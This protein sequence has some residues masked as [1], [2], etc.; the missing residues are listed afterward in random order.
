MNT[1]Q[2]LRL[3]AEQLVDILKRELEL[4]RHNLLEELH[5]KT[6][7]QIFIE[8]R[9]YKQI[10]ECKTYD[11]VIKAVFKGLE[12]FRPKLRR[13]VTKDDIEMLLGVRIKRISRFDINKNRKDIEDILKELAEV[14]KNLKNLKAY[15]VRYLKALIKKYQKDYPRCTQTDT[16]KALDV[17]KLTSNELTINMDPEK[18]FL[19][20]S[21][22]GDE[23]LKCSSLD[24][25]LI[26]KKDGSFVVMPP[27]ETYFAN[28]GLVYCGIYQRGLVFTAVYT[29]WGV[30]LIKR[31]EIG[32][33]IMNKE[34]RYVPESARLD[35]CCLGTP[36]ELYVKYKPAKG[37][38][39]LQQRFQP[40][41]VL[42]KGVKAK[43]KQITA[44]SIAYIDEKPG[45]WWDK[46]IKSPKGLLL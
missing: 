17:R 43:G 24:K 2:V 18:G 7:I 12:P 46:N 11:A 33:T 45:R 9:I 38:R 13:D 30:T 20:T 21:V 16:F 27:P 6:L 42:I 19:G 31:F 32:G 37:L 8:N 40:D 44:K 4:R 10:E 39:I 25:L 22:K 1:E 41:Q 14:E 5:S 15:A 3:N 34:Y 28:D 23:L 29:D 26:V 36:D 35:F